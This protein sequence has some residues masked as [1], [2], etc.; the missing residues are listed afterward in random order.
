MDARTQPRRGLLKRAFYRTI[1][2]FIDGDEK[3][4]AAA[5]SH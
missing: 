4:C 2:K 1:T 5:D 3:L